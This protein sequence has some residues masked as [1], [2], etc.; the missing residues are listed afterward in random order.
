MI[1]MTDPR[2]IQGGVAPSST[3]DLLESYLREIRDTPVLSTPEQDRLCE[4]MER[5]EDALRQALAAIP[6]TARQIILL[7]RE[8]QAHGL[9]TGALSQLHRD[10]SGRNWSRVIDAKLGAAEAT[11]EA[12]GKA[13]AIRASRGERQALRDTL[14]E[15]ILEA[16]IALPL[17][18]SL[19]ERLPTAASARETGGAKRL[20]RLLGQADEALA[21]LSDSKNR[22]ITHNLRLVIRCAKAY[23]NQGVP[24]LDLI[25]EGN[26]G[27]IRAVEKFD[28]RRGYKF[29]TY[30]VWWIEQALVRAV[31]NGSRVVRVPSPLI[32]Q[33]RKLKRLEQSLRVALDEE[34]SAHELAGRLSSNLSEVDDLR[35]SL[36]PE[37]SCQAP[38]GGTES[39]TV[40]ETLSDSDPE[41]LA[42]ALDRHK[43]RVGFR[44]LMRELPERERRVIEWR[45][46]LGGRSPLTLSEIGKRLEV[47]RE[48]VR[49]I[50]KQ[51]LAMMGEQP[52]AREIAA[53]L[54]LH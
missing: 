26:A 28:H 27:L 46:G 20:E 33:Q 41:D 48:R 43:L 6:E 8:R 31:A 35:R 47:S 53:E 44:S 52:L 17:L 4:E 49:Q 42:T 54:D 13:I 34:P 50:E 1:S 22:F 11:L 18:I 21:R 2:P 7:W 25:Q 51:A 39:L 5:A 24:F 14:A 30:A 19:L 16:Q 32:D 15:Q 38:V 40:E 23:R 36:S 29:S 12:L 37:V 9:V 10:G 45:F 3:G